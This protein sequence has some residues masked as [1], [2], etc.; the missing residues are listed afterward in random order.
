[1]SWIEIIGYAGSVLIAVSL[2]MKSMVRLRWINLFG[3][4]TFATYGY[5][6]DAYPVLML[7]GFITVV[8]IF[9][10][11]QMYFKKD[12]FEV[13]LVKS[14]QAPFV[15]RFLEYYREDMRYF[16]PDVAYDEIREPLIFFTVRN[17][18][19]VGLFIGEP[20]GEGVLEI[21]VE[22]AIPDYRDLKNAFYLYDRR[23]EHFLKHGFRT[24]RIK[25]RVPEHIRFI[26]RMGFRA[27]SAKGEHWYSMALT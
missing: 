21:K 4:S 16:F 11:L 6:I 8:D 13:F 23:Q 24:L 14:L 10:L 1:M 3:A 17:M 15:R 12:Y 20:A 18:L 2:M 22:Y 19:P 9:Y 25:T 26:K 5:I 7:N 27:D